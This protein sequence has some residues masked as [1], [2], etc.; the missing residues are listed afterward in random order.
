MNRDEEL[1]AAW[2]CSQGRAV[3]HMRNGEDPP[4]IVVEG[5]IAVEVTTIA[6]YA[7]RTLW[8]FMNSVC[9]SLGPAEEDRGYFIS[10]SSA[11]PS[12]LQGEDRHR[13]AAIKQ[14]VRRSARLALRNHYANPDAKLHGPNGRVGLPHGVEFHI[15]APMRENPNGVKYAVASSGAEAVCVVPHLIETVQSA[16]R[17]K[18]NN[19]RQNTKN[20]G[21]SSPIRNTRRDSTFVKYRWW[22]VPFATISLGNEYS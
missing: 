18:A 14:Q 20:G 11:D 9:K 17:K 3:C 1:V 2:L 15:I 6:S 16:I 13:I 10:V 19:K 12:L 8:D 4:D 21:W 5:N 22:P 7:Y